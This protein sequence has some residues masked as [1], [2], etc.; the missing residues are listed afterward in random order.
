MLNLRTSAEV[1]QA[2]DAILD[3]V[4]QHDPRP[5]RRASGTTHGTPQR[6]WSY[7]PLAAGSCLRPRHPARGIRRRAPRHGRGSSS[8]NQALARYQIIGALKDGKIREQAS[9]VRLDIDA[10]GRCCASSPSCCWPS[11]RYKNWICT[12]CRPVAK[13]W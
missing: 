6:V 12:R 1:A 8:L 2:A 11:P 9:P 5:H 3:R 4:R 13:R 7:D 10:L